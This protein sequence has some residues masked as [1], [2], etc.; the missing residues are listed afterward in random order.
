MT[1]ALC[2]LFQCFVHILKALP[3]IY[4]KAFSKQA[5]EQSIK[6]LALGK[7]HPLRL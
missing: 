3:D 4:I 6:Y 7:A 2:P 5:D 1:A